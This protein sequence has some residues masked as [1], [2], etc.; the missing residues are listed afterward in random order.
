MK[1]KLWSISCYNKCVF[2][3]L[4]ALFILIAGTL[5]VAFISPLVFIEF[6]V[7]HGYQKLSQLFSS[8][9]KLF[10]VVEEVHDLESN[11]PSEDYQVF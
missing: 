6:L 8:V 9:L 5:Y 1:N 7:Y 3:I 4:T 2:H 11:C 10:V